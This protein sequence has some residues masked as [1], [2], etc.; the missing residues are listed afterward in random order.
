MKQVVSILIFLL[1]LLLS[2]S[3]FAQGKE[4]VWVV[5]S[6]KPSGYFDPVEYFDPHSVQRRVRQGLPLYDETDLP[7][8]VDYI[9]RVEEV[10]GRVKNVSRW[11]NAVTV[12]AGRKEQQELSRLPFVA[13]IE[14]VMHLTTSSL[15]AF[16]QEFPWSGK[17]GKLAKQQLALM[18]GEVFDSL[19]IDGRGVRIALFDA[20]FP[21]VDYHP[22]FAHIR[23][24]GRIVATHDFVKGTDDVF[25]G[26]V[27]GTMVLSC[28][29]GMNS[30][31]T[32]GLATGAEFLLART[33]QW[34]EPFSEEVN[35]VCA[36]EWADRHGVDIINSSLG[37]TYHRYFPDEM[38]GRIAMVSRAAT[39]AA[40]KGILVVN[41]MGNAGASRWEILGAPAD[42]DSI[43]SVGG[44]DPYTGRHMAFSSFGPSAD[45]RLKPNVC[46]PARAAAAG[47][48]KVKA[49]Y[50]TSFSAPLV[51]GF[52]ACVMQM[53][54]EWNNMELL[55]A[56]ERSGHLYPYYDYAHGYG[57]PQA[58][59]FSR[60]KE[61]RMTSFTILA[62]EE[63]LAVKIR[64]IPPDSTEKIPS[65]LYYHIASPGGLL[66]KYAVIEVSDSIPLVIS[67]KALN[68]DD[69]LRVYYRGQIRCLSAENS[70]L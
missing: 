66:K 43:L 37:Y 67:L 24:E 15:K 47:R 12:H 1:F 22:L 54:P 63:S 4:K 28:I 19:G 6:D 3:L 68:P 9:R 38:N 58:S 53:H 16:P 32:L 62:N 64:E 56:M 36:M 5:F 14:P 48:R 55:H 60:K 70:D 30:E 25:S 8:S 59:Y 57:I 65:Y 52:A 50:G 2:A 29:A 33:E 26:N 44:V 51:T 61:D 13:S 18:E 46:A 10:A 17:E 31:W 35:W 23:E 21:G 11:L 27:H 39:L 45:G 34:G 69:F 42:A 41:A 7:V 40:R 20:G 49:A